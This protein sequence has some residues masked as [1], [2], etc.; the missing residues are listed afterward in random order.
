[1]CTTGTGNAQ[2]PIL[3]CNNIMTLIVDCFLAVAIADTHTCWLIQHLDLIGTRHPPLAVVTALRKGN[4]LGRHTCARSRTQAA[5]CLATASRSWVCHVEKCPRN[6]LGR[7]YYIV[8]SFFFSTC[9][10]IYFG[11]VLSCDSCLS[12][13]PLSLNKVG[14]VFYWW[15]LHL[16]VMG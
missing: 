2:H 14:A 13:S 4:A 5:R 16:W 15:T 7:Y 8:L 9:A 11:M 12:L 6:W 10:M 3:V 1:M